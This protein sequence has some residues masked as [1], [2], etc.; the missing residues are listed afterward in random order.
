MGQTLL[1]DADLIPL[2]MQMYPGNRSEKPYM[3]MVIEEM[4]QRYKVSGRTVQVADKGLN[5]ARNIYSAVKEADDG[6]IFSKSIKGTSLSRKEKE[7]ILLEND[8]NI[9]TDYTDDSGKIML[10]LKTCVDTISYS[11]KEVDPE[12]ENEKVTSFSV[13]EKRVVSY[14]PALATKQKAEIMKMV[15]KASDFT[16]YKQI[17]KEELDESAKY[18]K[19]T[20]K[21]STGKTVKPF[22]SINIEESF[23]VTK[24]YLDARPVYAQKKESIYGH[25]LICYISLFLLRVLELKCFK[26]TINAYDLISFIRDFILVDKG[27]ATYINISK[28][29]AVNEKIKAVTGLTTLDAL[30]LTEKEVNNL[31]RNC[32]LIDN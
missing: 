1:L 31:F 13:R 12:T 24:S 28:N 16:T 20:N 5:C 10:R 26:G 7:W 18:I 25:F 23:R 3:R 11:F 8:E 22:I 2:A 4:K 29:Q 17:S 14:N 32:I 21:D 19:V 27:D 6:Y 30:F 9:F 15:D